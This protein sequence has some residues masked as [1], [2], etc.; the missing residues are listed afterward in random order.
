MV[1]NWTDAVFALM[2][3]LPGHP[4][5]PQLKGHAALSG[6]RANPGAT[7]K[8]EKS[9]GRSPLG[10]A[11]T[12]GVGSA[13]AGSEAAARAGSG[14]ILGFSGGSAPL[15]MG[16]LAVVSF[17]AGAVLSRSPVC[18]AVLRGGRRRRLS[19]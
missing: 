17:V 7:R 14:A 4:S 1:G 6:R 19:G 9:G 10:P 5:L 12:G 18:A 8:L 3:L 13:Q 2:E 11:G 16:G 15:P